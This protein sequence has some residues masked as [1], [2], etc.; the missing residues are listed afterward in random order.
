MLGILIT[1]LIISSVIC[2]LF[3]GNLSEVSAS[4]LGS[5]NK[6][7][8]L[9]LY[10]A[11]SMAL[12]GGLMRIAERSGITAAVCRIL[13]P[14]TKFLFKDIEKDPDAHIAV[15]MNIAA[16]LFGLGNAATPLGIA[17]AKAL[18]SDCSP[19]SVR[20][21]AMLVVLNTA[22]I[23]LIPTTIGAMRLAHGAQSPFDITL[24]IL[25]VSLISAAAGCLAVYALYLPQRK[26]HE[27]K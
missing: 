20:N 24:P 13:R 19:H 15:S 4:A 6:A 26:H 16:N 8:E 3:T 21:T 9:V 18:N 1:I 14:V 25:A 17:A 10:L 5:C 27:V 11:G 12:W 23:Q 7:V 2:A 22:S